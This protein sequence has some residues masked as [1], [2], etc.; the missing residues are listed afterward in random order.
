MKNSMMKPGQGLI[1]ISEPFLAD[2]YFKRSV[3]LI[4]EIDP[5]GA[6]GFILNKPTDLSVN[7]AIEGIPQFNAPLYFGGPVSTETL[8]YIH[9]KGD[10]LEGSREI[11]KGVYWGGDF[12]QLKVL[13]ETGQITPDEIRFYAGYSGWENEQ[14]DFELQEHAWLLSNGSVK[15]SFFKDPSKLWKQAIKSMGSKYAPMANFPEDP[16]LN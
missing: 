13:M 5:E 16:S 12:D 3:V 2:S 6:M 14:L 8:Y 4:S 10:L 1:L 15:F 11:I 9:T 7:D